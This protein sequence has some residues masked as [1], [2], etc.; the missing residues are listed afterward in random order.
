MGK[1]DEAL[2][3]CEK[4]RSEVP[5][6]DDV[7]RKLYFVHRELGRCRNF[8]QPIFHQMN[9]LFFFKSGFTHQLLWKRT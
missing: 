5:V 2:V 3:E 9:N 7:L 4:V 8:K 1:P 6:D